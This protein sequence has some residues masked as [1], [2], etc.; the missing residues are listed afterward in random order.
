MDAVSPFEPTVVS[1]AR[2]YW[3]FILVVVLV[4]TVP[5]GLYAVTRPS[6]SSATASLTV[7]D[8]RGPG[9]LGGQSPADPDRYV[10]DQL[11]VFRSANLGVR[12]ARHAAAQKPPL[13]ETSAWFAAHTSATASAQDNN[14]L[15]VSFSAPT[16]AEAIGGL[17]AVVAGYGDVVK[18]SAASQ[19]KTVLQQLDSSINLLDTQLAALRAA[20]RSATTTAQIDQLNASRAAQVARRAQV[21]SE[22]AFPGTGIQQTLLSDPATSSG[23]SAALRLIVVAILFGLLVGIG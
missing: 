20:P 7:S 23:T 13:K 1:A 4:V 6:S 17:R 2:R 5:V 21:A 19:A 10:S 9:T 16:G 3:L 18:A 14:V 8:P 12:A 11:V 22:A 15:S